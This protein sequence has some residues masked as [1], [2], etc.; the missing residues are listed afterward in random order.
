MITV[1]LGLHNSD[2]YFLHNVLNGF[3]CARR[4]G[5]SCAMPTASTTTICP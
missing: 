2:D 1:A 5:Q 3:F 4:V